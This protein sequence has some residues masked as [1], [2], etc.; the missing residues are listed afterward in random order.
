MRCRSK[1]LLFGGI[2]PVCFLNINALHHYWW[3]AGAPAGVLCAECNFIAIGARSPLRDES[4]RVESS[5]IKSSAKSAGTIFTVL[6]TPKPIRRQEMNALSLTHGI[7]NGK[8][9]TRERLE[10]PTSELIN[11]GER[12]LNARLTITRTSAQTFR[13]FW[14]VTFATSSGNMRRYLSKHYNCGL[15]II[16]IWDVKWF[17]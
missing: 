2:Q 3:S 7:I 10:Y 4:R 15:R 9:S 14:D 1:L 6:V 13:M 5:R 8:G 12:E 16:L 11:V 17:L